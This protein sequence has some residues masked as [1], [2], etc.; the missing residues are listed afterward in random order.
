[1][2]DFSARFVDVRARRADCQLYDPNSYASSQRFG[3]GVLDA[4][5]NGIVYRSVRDPA[6]ECLACFRPASLAEALRAKAEGLRYT[7]SRTRRTS[8]MSS[9]GLK[10]FASSGRTL[11]PALSRS[12]A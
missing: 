1:M 9:R 7:A 12:P 4:G 2:A 3:Q 8:S 11:P 10:G 5:G 6:G